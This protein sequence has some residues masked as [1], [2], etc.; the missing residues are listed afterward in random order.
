M[1][2]VVAILQGVW[3][4]IPAYVANSAAVFLG[5]GRPIDGGAILR[6]GRRVLGGGKTWRGLVG[7][8]LFGMF[9]GILQWLGNSAYG[10]PDFSFGDFPFT[11]LVI[12]LL[13]FGAL[14]G[15][16]LGSFIKR[17]MGIERGQK[18]PGL[19][20]YDFLIGVV[21]LVGIF[22]TGW[23]LEHYIYGFAILGLI[24]VIVLTPILHRITNIIGHKMGKKEVPW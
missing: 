20:Q 18:A 8:T 16:I 15:D 7:G 17:R 13:P 12:F 23:F 1:D 11:I 3:L 5:G 19:D 9:I 4:M 21:I 22:Q 2:P 24:T 14:F 10:H 6:D